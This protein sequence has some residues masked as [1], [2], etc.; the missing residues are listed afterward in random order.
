M[1][2]KCI[3]DGEGVKSKGLVVG[4]VIPYRETL[5]TCKV[6]HDTECLVNNQSSKNY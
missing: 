2:R 4:D 3:V 6:E 1:V 5:I